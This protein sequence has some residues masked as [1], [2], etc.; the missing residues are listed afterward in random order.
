MFAAIA[1]GAAQFWP[2]ERSAGVTEIV[3]YPRATVLRIW[4][5]GGDLDELREMHDAACDWGKTQGCHMVQILGRDGWARALD[6]YE[7]VH[8]VMGKKL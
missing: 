2:G 4:L 8:V 6:G 3:D 7:K 5:A 1:E